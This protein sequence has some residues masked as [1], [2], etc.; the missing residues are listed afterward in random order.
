MIYDND[1]PIYSVLNGKGGSLTVSGLTGSSS[2]ANGV[3]VQAG[4]YN[5]KP[6][7]AKGSYVQTTYEPFVNGEYII[8]WAAFG[9]N[10]WNWYNNETASFSASNT[11]DTATPPT[12]A[13]G[14]I[15]DWCCPDGYFIIT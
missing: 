5:G 15:T 6:Y 9:F 13:D 7:Y 2:G 4:T 11:N 12:R 14:E 1:E 3:Y 10:V 8:I